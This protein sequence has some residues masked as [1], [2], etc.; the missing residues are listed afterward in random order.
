MTTNHSG[1]AT[2]VQTVALRPAVAG[3]SEILCGPGLLRARMA[4]F[5]EYRILR[6]S[7]PLP[8]R[9][10]FWFFQFDTLTS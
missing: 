1:P 5:G 2:R 7:L 8:V 4:F 3:A 9:S 6:S 10:L